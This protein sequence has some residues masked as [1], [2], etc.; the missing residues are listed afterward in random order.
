[1]PV[2]RTICGF[3]RVK[4]VCKS[5][6]TGFGGFGV[7]GGRSGARGFLGVAWLSF[8]VWSADKREKERNKNAE[9]ACEAH[10]SGVARWSQ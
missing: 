4:A 8:F 2:G 3:S 1:M 7:R 10:A 6:K 9:R 5:R